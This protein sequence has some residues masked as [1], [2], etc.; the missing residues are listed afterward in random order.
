M[1][2]PILAVVAVAALVAAVVWGRSA[3]HL[4]R[5]WHRIEDDLGPDA[6]AT[7]LARSSYRKEVHTV[8]LYAVLAVAAAV[9]AVLDAE[10]GGA[11]VRLHP[12]AGRPLGAVPPRLPAR[13]TARRGPQPARAPGRGGAVPGGAGAA[14]LGGPA[15]AR[16]PARLRR[17]R[18]GPRVPGRHRAHGRRLLRRV[19][20]GAHAHRGGHRRRH[21]PRHRAVDHRLPGQVPA[22]RVPP[23]VP[24]S[25]AGARGAQPADVGARARRGVHLD[26]RGG[27]RHRGGHPARGIGRS[28]RRRGSGTTARCGR[29]APPV[30]C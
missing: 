21:R 27:V 5:V 29:S 20:G 14:A 2:K 22:A 9:A 24:R 4:Q 10:R 18:A 26:L 28:S 25:G 16:G 8:T 30:R 6:D 23:P 15:G 13:G 11:P 7:V 12:R 19:P 3:Q 1:D 17:L